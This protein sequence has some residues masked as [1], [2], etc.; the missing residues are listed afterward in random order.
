MYRVEVHRFWRSA[1][2]A[3]PGTLLVGL[4]TFICYELGLSLT[5][6]SFLY[7]IVV[8]LQSLLGDFALGTVRL[9]PVSQGDDIVLVASD[10][11]YKLYGD[12]DTLLKLMCDRAKVTGRLESATLEVETI[13]RA[14]KK[15]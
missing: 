3:I 10:K 1:T 5:V 6:P 7:L 9:S 4:A 2:R 13:A 11:T 12:K 14:P 8:V 15:K